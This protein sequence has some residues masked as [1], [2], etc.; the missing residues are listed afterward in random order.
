LEQTFEALWAQLGDGTQ[1]IPQY[2]FAH[3][4]YYVDKAGRRRQRAWAFDFAWPIER[5]A[6]EIEGGIWSG[7]RHSRGA[8]MIADADKYNHAA[9]DGWLLLRYTSYHI[10]HD[11]YAMIE[12]V[13]EALVKRR[14]PD[15]RNGGG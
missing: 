8:G 6:V 14:Q 9:L 3:H 11:P 10:T 2:Q 4:V 1:P 7:G 15:P 13:K 12:Q 5:V